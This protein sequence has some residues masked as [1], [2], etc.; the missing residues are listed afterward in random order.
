MGSPVGKG[1]Q[2]G[3]LPPHCAMPWPATRGVNN[4]PRPPFVLKA[5]SISRRIM[6]TRV[7]IPMKDSEPSTDE[8][9]LDYLH[10]RDP[11]ASLF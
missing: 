8:P 1:R 10:Y 7:S 6:R 9:T 2:I 4:A 5:S 3:T 11:G